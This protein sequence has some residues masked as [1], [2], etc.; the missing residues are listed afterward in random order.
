[1]LLIL[2]LIFLFVY[3]ILYF[4]YYLFGKIYGNVE[5]L[6]KYNV[7]NFFP[8]I[9]IIVPTYNEEKIIDEKIKNLI[10]VNYPPEKMEIIF[11]DCSTDGTT[12]KIKDFQKTSKYKIEL[13]HDL[14]REGLSD[15]LNR[16][17]SMAKGEIVIKSDADILMESD[18]LI[19]IVKF[20][21]NNDVAGVSGVGVTNTD[22]DKTYSTVQV[23]LRIAE[24]NFCSTYLF[25]TFCAFKKRFVDPIRKDSAADDAEIAINMIR[26]GYKTLVN[27]NARFHSKSTIKFSER[28]KQKD[29]RAEGHIRLILQNADI[30]FNKRYGKFGLYVFP[31]IFWMMIIT[32][33][34][35]ILLLVLFFSVIW[36]MM[37]FI[38]LLIGLF[39]I[40]LIIVFSYKFSFLS[41]LGVFFDSQ[42]SLILAQLRVI[43][44][45]KTFKWEKVER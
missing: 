42:L 38:Y 39:S 22:F 6:S 29:R 21:G 9:S 44:G 24:S 36:V 30:I 43:S 13:V 45:K 19:E 25:D 40:I 4:S 3:L 11:M 14:E 18:S 26:K 28:R 12:N 10:D 34:F 37:G 31:M 32:P 2:F 41:K 1:L 27:P 17:Y 7:E 33:W 20:L 15:A 8:Y 35:S 23:K 5:K 16:G